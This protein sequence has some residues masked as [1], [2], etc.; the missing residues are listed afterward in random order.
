MTSLAPVSVDVERPGLRWRRESDWIKAI[1]KRI[2]GPRGIGIAFAASMIAVACTNGG[3]S[4]APTIRASGTPSASATASAPSLVQEDGAPLGPGTYTTI[5]HPKITFSTDASWVS[6]AD[7]P[8]FVSFER[9]DGNG[10]IS[11]KRIDKVVNPTRKGLMP[12]PKDYVGWIVSLP[13]VKVIAGPKA[14]TVDGVAATAIDVTAT[15]DAPT[16]YCKDPCVAL[17]P[18]RHPDFPGEVASLSPDWVSRIV[19][20]RLHGETV[21]MSTCCASGGADFRAHTQNFDTIIKSVHFG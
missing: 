3:S 13:S 10:G 4:A 16:M 12:V 5:F 2:A 8:D 21:E 15:R 19:V 9:A 1:M 18:L 11:F 14:V 7:K 17:W 20:I 6:Y